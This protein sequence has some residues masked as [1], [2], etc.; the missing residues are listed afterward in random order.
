MVTHSHKVLLDR[1]G[2]Y[3]TK[4]CRLTSTDYTKDGEPMGTDYLH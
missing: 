2:L 1:P 4:A 3:G